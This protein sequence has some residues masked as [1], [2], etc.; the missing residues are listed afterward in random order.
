VTAASALGVSTLV[1]ASLCPITFM[2]SAFGAAP[3]GGSISKNNPC[4]PN[5]TKCGTGT[6]MPS[7]NMNALI[8]AILERLWLLMGFTNTLDTITFR[9]TVRLH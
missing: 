5:K 4:N 3:Q 1:V 2:D 7:Q 6:K 9:A 8:A